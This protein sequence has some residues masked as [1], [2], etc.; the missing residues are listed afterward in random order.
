MIPKRD[1]GR[2]PKWDLRMILRRDLGEDSQMEFREDSQVFCG[3]PGLWWE[4][5]ASVPL[6]KKK[7][8]WDLGMIPKFFWGCSQFLVGKLGLE[9]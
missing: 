6:K 9:P 8:E 5:W 2:I 1:L 3:F 7:G 4:N